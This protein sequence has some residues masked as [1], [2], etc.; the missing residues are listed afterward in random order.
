MSKL[1]CW[2]LPAR[3]DPQDFPVCWF[4]ICHNLIHHTF[5]FLFV[6][7]RPLSEFAAKVHLSIILSRQKHVRT[8]YKLNTCNFYSIT[9]LLKDD[10]R[11]LYGRRCGAASF[12]STRI[13][14]TLTFYSLNAFQSQI[15]TTVHYFMYYF[16]LL[17]YHTNN[18]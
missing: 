13:Q 12:H 3:I 16:I 8:D 17:N 9:N 1:L 10:K 11:V 4:Q 5:L 18:F 7:S 15:F 6:H 2:E 14:F